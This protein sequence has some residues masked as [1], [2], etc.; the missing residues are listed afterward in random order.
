MEKHGYQQYEISNFS[1]KGYESRHNLTYWN[2]DHYYGFG[3]GAHSYLTG[4]RRSN[5]GPLKKYMTPIENRQLPIMDEN[6]LTNKEMWEEEMFLGLRKTKGISI[7]HFSR[8]FGKSPL[9][10]FEN[11]I[12]QLKK[13]K[14]IDISEG[15]IFLTQHGRFLGN[16]AFQAF[17]L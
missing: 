5:Y 11:Q 8:K 1:K 6:L 14:L 13:K 2:N 15:Y 17:L 16:E 3:A 4:V 7:N 12:E 9:V 10:I